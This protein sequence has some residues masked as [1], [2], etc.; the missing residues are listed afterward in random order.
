MTRS[1]RQTAKTGECLSTDP[2][3]FTSCSFNFGEVI[4]QRL[5]PVIQTGYYVLVGAGHPRFKN[6]T[7]S[8]YQSG[9]RGINIE[10]KCDLHAALMEERPLDVNLRVVLSDRHGDAPF[11][12]ELND[13]L[14]SPCD[15]EKAAADQACDGAR[16]EVPMRTLSSVLAEASLDHIHF[17]GVNGEDFVEKVLDGNDWERFRP[18]VVI[19][20]VNFLESSTPRSSMIHRYMERRGYR[21]FYF[22]GLNDFYL[23]CEFEVPEGLILVPKVL[24]RDVPRAIADLRG[25]IQELQ[26]DFTTAE[27]YAAALERTVEALAAENRRLGHQ[28]VH[29]ASEN[30][31]LR[32]AAEQ[33]RA[34]LLVLNQLLEQLPAMAE[35]TDRG[36]RDHERELNDLTNKLTTEHQ[37]RQ[38]ELADLTNQLVSERR[39]HEQELAGLINRLVTEHQDRHQELADLTNQLVSE[40]RVHEQELAS[41]TNRLVTEHQDR[42]QELD[43]LT[44]QLVGVRRVHEEELASLTNRLV[45]EHQGYQQQLDDLTNQLAIEHQDRQQ[46]L[47]DITNRHVAERRVHEQELASLT[48]RLATEH[49]EYQ[50]Q[51][52]GF[53]NQLVIVRQA[54]EQELVAFDHRLVAANAR[55]KSVLASR[56]WRATAPLRWFDDTQRRVLK[57]LRMG[58]GGDE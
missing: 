7:F 5:F 42:Q 13:S 4:L 37:D 57:W 32:G 36:R 2:S 45:T 20:E 49:Q 41:L 38:Q 35:Q 18:D 55:L 52:A 8:L 34:E 17:L 19:V 47:T 15:L 46:E 40:R 54:H 26:P 27:E 1:D 30:R 29:L 51:L 56:S 14:P 16:S 53:T 31:R 43:D 21:H 12:H 25:R 33:M 22:D 10:A 11:F 39:V 48:N 28:Y 9:W 23:E 6:E 44:N 50:Q 58:I 24:D 3:S